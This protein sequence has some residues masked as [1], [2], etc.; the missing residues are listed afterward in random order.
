MD[1]KKLQELNNKLLKKLGE[2]ALKDSKTRCPI[3]QEFYNYPQVDI[4]GNPECESILKYAFDK[5][6]EDMKNDIFDKAFSESDCTTSATK[7]EMNEDAIKEMMETLKKEKIKPGIIEILVTKFVK[8]D[9][10]QILHDKYL[11]MNAKTYQLIKDKKVEIIKSTPFGIP[12]FEGEEAD[13]RYKKYFAEGLNIKEF[14][15]IGLFGMKGDDDEN[16]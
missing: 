7:S 5:A 8:G 13:E 4:Y 1:Y 3:L 12:V 11:C 16:G 14:S 9:D 15:N 2:K 10:C 6:M